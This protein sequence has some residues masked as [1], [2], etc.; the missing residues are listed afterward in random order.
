M[1]TVTITFTIN[2]CLHIFKDVHAI[3]RS[4]YVH[5]MPVRPAPMKNEPRAGNRLP[6]SVPE[7]VS[8]DRHNSMCFRLG[9]CVGAKNFPPATMAIQLEDVNGNA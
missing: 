7:H 3:L 8:R 2:I 4:T 6:V 1:V 5:R 9:A